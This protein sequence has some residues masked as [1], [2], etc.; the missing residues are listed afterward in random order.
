M[1]DI[2]SEF[3]DFIYKYCKKKWNTSGLIK[4]NLFDKITKRRYMFGPNEMSWSMDE[5]MNTWHIF[6]HVWNS[7][8][9]MDEMIPKIERFFENKKWNTYIRFTEYVGKNDRTKNVAVGIGAKH[10]QELEDL[11]YQNIP[12]YFNRTHYLSNPNKVVE[13][14]IGMFCIEQSK[15]ILK[16]D[17]SEKMMQWIQSLKEKQDSFQ[18]IEKELSE[19]IL[20]RTAKIRKEKTSL[21]LGK[22]KIGFWVKGVQDEIRIR[23]GKKTIKASSTEEAVELVKQELEQLLEKEKVRMLL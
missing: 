13:D 14:E 22:K 9:I 7:E 16:F 5:L 6:V 18:N 8:P 10:A 1:S 12:L 2:L 4:I 11:Y 20:S 17:Q 15:K 21:F 19:W 23:L 3:E